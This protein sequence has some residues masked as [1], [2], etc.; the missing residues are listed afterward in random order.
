MHVQSLGS[1]VAFQ[2]TV[3]IA[4]IGMYISYALPI[5]LRITVA[6][7]RFVAGPFNLGPRGGIL[8]GWVA[9]SWVA[10]ITI[11]FSMPVEYPITQES[12]NYTPVAVGGLF[13]VVCGAWYF[14]G[15]RVWFKG[16]V[17]NVH[18]SFTH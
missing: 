4:T 16:P 12:L 18:P 3:S 9:V 14:G 7:K 15:V 8:V 5:L 1:Q 17:P 6:R 11:L 13:V 2:A 10:F